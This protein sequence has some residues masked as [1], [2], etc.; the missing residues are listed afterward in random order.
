MT[1]QQLAI[2]T[3]DFKILYTILAIYFALQVVLI[4]TVY[5]VLKDRLEKVVPGRNTQLNRAP[6]YDRARREHPHV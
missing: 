1:A 2:V 4:L 6:E 3:N 5:Y